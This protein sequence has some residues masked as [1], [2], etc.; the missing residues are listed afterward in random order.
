[1]ALYLS[2]IPSTCFIHRWL[3]F[4]IRQL[5]TPPPLIMCSLSL[6]PIMPCLS[7]LCQTP[8]HLLGFSSLVDSSQKPSLIFLPPP[9]VQLFASPGKRMMLQQV[10]SSLLPSWLLSFGEHLSWLSFIFGFSKAIH[11]KDSPK[12][13][14]VKYS[15]F[16]VPFS[17]SGVMARDYRIYD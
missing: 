1:M 16:L 4:I 15:E 7:F 9:R 6:L 14:L 13:Y 10:S 2:T 11:S 5:I 8:T 12:K 17:E 3:I